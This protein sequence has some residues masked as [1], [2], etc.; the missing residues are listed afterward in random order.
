M[1]KRVNTSKLGEENLAATKFAELILDISTILL[2]S[3]AHCERICRNIKRISDKS[4]YNIELL[5]TFTGISV[6]AA[7]KDN[8]QIVVTENR[9]VRHHGAHFGVL[10][11]TSLLTWK[12][13]DEDISTDELRQYLEKIKSC[14]KYNTWIVRTFIGI[15]CGCLCLLARGDFIDGGFAFLASFVG[16]TVRQEMIKHRFNLMIAATCSAFITTTLSGI[17]VLERFGS[18]P[19]ISVATAVLFLIP[20]VPLINCIIDMLEGYIPMGLARGAFGGFILLC[21]AVGMFLSMTLLGV[22]NF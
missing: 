13:H 16:L 3:G 18:S 22:N 21:I 8:P 17:N 6:T 10:T 9:R 15:A 1:E 20:G 4:G 5:L 2:E 19:E 14:P 12:H 11:D 7:S